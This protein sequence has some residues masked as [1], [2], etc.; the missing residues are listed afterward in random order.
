MW[1]ITNPRLGW[2]ARR[3]GVHLTCLRSGS[4]ELPFSRA[5]D[6]SSYSMTLYEVRTGHIPFEYGCGHSSDSVSA[7]QLTTQC[8]CP[9]TCCTMCQTRLLATGYWQRKSVPHGSKPE[10]TAWTFLGDTQS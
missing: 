6:V 7:S 10:V 5:L 9:A 2:R 4:V 3:F 8:P 1:Q